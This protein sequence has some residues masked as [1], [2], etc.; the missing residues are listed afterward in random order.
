MNTILTD[1]KINTEH[2]PDGLTDIT[3]FENLSREDKINHI[4]RKYT[5]GNDASVESMNKCLKYITDSAYIN[6]YVLEAAIKE[7]LKD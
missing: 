2:G 3:Q 5:G 7:I 1:N 4:F 6:E